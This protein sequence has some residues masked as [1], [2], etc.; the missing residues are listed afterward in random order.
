M[1]LSRKR[2]GRRHKQGRERCFQRKPDNLTEG[3]EEAEF[4]R[5]SEMLGRQWRGLGQR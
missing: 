1:T 2:Y 5:I 3:P 4:D